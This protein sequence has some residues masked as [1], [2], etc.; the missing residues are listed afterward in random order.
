MSRSVVQGRTGGDDGPLTSKSGSL[1]IDS[2]IGCLL[3]H[4]CLVIISIC[5][6]LGVSSIGPKRAASSQISYGWHGMDIQNP[7][8]SGSQS[9]TQIISL[10]R[11]T[12]L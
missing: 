1:A 3:L 11:L 5:L 6:A 8:L 4:R 10:L 12:Y 7:D 9:G 2:M